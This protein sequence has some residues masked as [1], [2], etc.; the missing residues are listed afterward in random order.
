[1]ERVVWNQLLILKLIDYYGTITR[2]ELIQKIFL[3]QVEGRNE[4]RKTFN[5][6]FYVVSK[7]PVSVEVNQDLKQMEKEGYIKCERVYSLTAKGKNRLNYYIDK[8]KKEK[9][10]SFMVFLDYKAKNSS[11]E[12]IVKNVIKKREIKDYDVNPY[13]TVIPQ[14]YNRET[15]KKAKVTIRNIHAMLEK[16]EK[17]CVSEIGNKGFTKEQKL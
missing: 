16:M 8:I 10:D 5:Y 7:Q 4:K 1:M 12:E 2:L 3:L 13:T 17:Q 11:I 6:P 9:V 15:G 14:H